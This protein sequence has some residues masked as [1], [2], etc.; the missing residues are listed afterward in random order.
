MGIGSIKIENGRIFDGKRYTYGDIYIE[1]DKIMAIGENISQKANY[2]FNAN[3]NLVTPGLCDIHAHMKGISSDAFGIS[4]DAVCFPN[5][6]TNAVDASAY[7]GSRDTLDAFSAKNRVFV[8]TDIKDDTALFDRTDKL[9]EVYG[10]KAVGI[11]V[12]FDTAEKTV[13]TINPLYEIV[14][15]A[16][17]RRIKVMVHCAGSPTPI[18]DVLEA[19]RTGDIITH[20]FHGVKNTALD[21]N[22]ESLKK[23]Q[24]RGVIIDSGFAGCVHT[25]FDIFKK[26]IENGMIPD[27]LSSDITC[28]SAF[29]RGGMYGMGACMM[30]AEKSGMSEEQIL[31]CVTVNAAKAVGTDWGILKVGRV[32][33]VAVFDKGG[34]GI[35]MTDK[36]GNRFVCDNSYRC[37]L[38]VCDGNVVYRL[39]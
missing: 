3:G 10:D 7:K 25:N 19:L 17:K 28:C 30:I 32:A 27:T 8:V 1:N 9:L 31:R 21:D 38:T 2:N 20:S 11:K 36:D 5:G 15:Y 33:D 34:K 29:I 22:F 16:D 26:A 14:K 13:R 37:L 6:V 39:T 35:D 4:I 23:A 24:K 18:S 12:Y